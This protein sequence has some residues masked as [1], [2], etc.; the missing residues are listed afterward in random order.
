MF[1]ASANGVGFFGTCLN[2]QVKDVTFRNA[3]INTNNEYAGVVVGNGYPSMNNVVV[4]NSEVTS[5][6][7]KV[8]GL[9]G[10][11][12]EGTMKFTN[13]HVRNTKVTGTTCV[14]GLV[15]FANYT[16]AATPTVR[17][18]GC[19]AFAVNVKGDGE[20]SPFVGSVSSTGDI[21]YFVMSN[22]S[23]ANSQIDCPKIP[24]CDY[25]G[26]FYWRAKA[27]QIIVDG[28]VIAEKK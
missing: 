5:S 20:T 9:V 23:I 26:A 21:D 12:S 27:I 28:V 4:E 19:S 13:C 17:I 16:G 14:G 22:V 18:D 10:Q 8:G 6:L 7:W 11:W 3:Y 24:I 15:G 2:L 1:S 25:V